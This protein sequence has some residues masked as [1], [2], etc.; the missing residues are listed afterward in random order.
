MGVMCGIDAVGYQAKDAKKTSAEKPSQV[1]EHLV[2]LVNPTGCLGIVGVYIAPD[3]GGVDKAAK[4]GQYPLPW[5]KLFDKGI[6]VGTGQTPVKKYIA[7]LR[8]LISAGRAKPSFIVSHRLPLTDAPDAYQKFDQRID[9][10]TKVIL[11]P[12]MARA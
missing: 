11:K 8:D 9:G 5:A 4:Q 2:E 6:T 10:Y 12:G 7:M 3:P 1:L